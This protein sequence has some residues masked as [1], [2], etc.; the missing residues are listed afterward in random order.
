[1]AGIWHSLLT[2]MEEHLVNYISK[3]SY[4][5]IMLNNLKNFMNV[6]SYLTLETC[7]WYIWVMETLVYF[8]SNLL[9]LPSSLK[10]C[11]SLGQPATKHQHGPSG[12][13]PTTRLCHT[14][15]LPGAG[16]ARGSWEWTV[17]C[18]WQWACGTAQSC[19]TSHSSQTPH[20]PADGQPTL[21]AA[22]AAADV[23]PCCP[24]ADAASG[25]SSIEARKTSRET[26]PTV[27]WGESHQN[28]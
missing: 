1:M 16:Q 4:N 6:D 24:H 20:R 25:A 28:H 13:D 23:P 26:L 27:L 9:F 14:L 7:Y 11:C 10:G 22:A 3:Y 21:N 2:W 15:L 18:P 12:A 19:V 5:S 17:V 8:S